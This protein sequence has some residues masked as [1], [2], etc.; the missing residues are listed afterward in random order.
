MDST[1]SNQPQNHYD[2][3]TIQKLGAMVAERELR[4]EQLQAELAAQQQQQALLM[5]RV[6]SLEAGEP[7]IAERE[8]PPPVSSARVDA[9]LATTEAAASDALNAAET[10]AETAGDGTGGTLTD[11]MEEARRH[12]ADPEPEGAVEALLGVTA[13]AESRGES[14]IGDDG[15]LREA[16]HR[17]RELVALRCLSRVNPKDRD[18][19]LVMAEKAFGTQRFCKHTRAQLLLACTKMKE[20][21]PD[22]FISKNASRAPRPRRVRN[23]WK[24]RAK[25][26]PPAVGAHTQRWREEPLWVPRPPWAPRQGER[27]RSD[28]AVVSLAPV[29]IPSVPALAVG[30]LALASSGG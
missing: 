30:A 2:E 12:L 24:P 4:I 29:S 19:F 11:V 18:A 20:L 16:G 5:E 7:R 3:A 25:S 21:A 17:L 22:I 13:F 8:E 10:A 23:A 1:T 28:Q 14:I 6:A 27:V 26:A 15:L 9:H